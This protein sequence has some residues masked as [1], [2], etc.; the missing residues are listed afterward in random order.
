MIH[1]FWAL[2]SYSFEFD[3][4]VANIVGIDPSFNC[5]MPLNLP[6]SGMYMAL[7]SKCS[8]QIFSFLKFRLEHIWICANSTQTCFRFSLL[9][10]LYKIWLSILVIGRSI[11]IKLKIKG[12]YPQW[13]FVQIT[14]AFET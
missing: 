4:D 5:W 2:F 9:G 1:T 11:R 14:H 10:N 12:F 8:E 6:S 7:M 13:V 3:E